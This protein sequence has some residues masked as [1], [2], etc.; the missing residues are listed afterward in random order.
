M[1]KNVPS[2]SPTLVCMKDIED[3][4][5]YYIVIEKKV[6]VSGISAFTKALNVWF[7]THYIF[8][9]EY[10]KAIF[11]VPLFIQEFVYGLPDT[12][13]KKTSTYLSVTSSIQSFA[14]A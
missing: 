14:A 9:L 11:E 4:A 3:I 12:S 2:L 5:T 6:V 1:A 8:N 13:T 7:A 10:E